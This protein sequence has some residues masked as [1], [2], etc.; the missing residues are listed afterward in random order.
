MIKAPKILSAFSLTVF[1]YMGVISIA[2]SDPLM[3]RGMSEFEFTFIRLIY[4]SAP[5][6]YQGYGYGVRDS[7]RIDWPDAENHFLQGLMRLTTVDVSGQGQL[8]SLIDEEL[9]DFPWLYVLEVGSW[10]LS[11]TEIQR[12][13]EYLLKGGFLMIDDFH[14]TREWAGFMATMRKV[15]PDRP[16]LEFTND[17]EVLHVLFDLDNRIQIPGIHTYWSGNTFEKDG[18]SPHWRGIYDDEGRLMVAI[19]FNMDIGDAWEHADHPNYPEPMTALAY[20]LGVNYVIYAMT[21]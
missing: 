6:M 1:V 19:N 21:H 7:W 18:I 3:K 9:F 8:L 12:L 17:D 2:S 15:F 20:R 4:N 13:R 16:V 14:G 10:V 11:E 5:T